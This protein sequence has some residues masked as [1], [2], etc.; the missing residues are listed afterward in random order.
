MSPGRAPRNNFAP[1]PL[2][3]RDRCRNRVIAVTA[4]VAVWSLLWGSFTW[5]NL[6]SGLAVATVVLTVFPLPP[7]TFAGRVHPLGVLRFA[8]R[9][10]LDL[11][12]S[13]VQVAALAFRIGHIPR[14]AVIAVPLAVPSDLNLTLTA[15]A[16]CLVPGSIVI[17]VDRVTGTLYVHVLGVRTRAEAERFRRSVWRLEARIITAIGSAAERHL[18]AASDLTGPQSSTDRKGP[19]A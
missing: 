6:I 4:L 3:R 9:F 11:V 14:S 5:A 7:V 13:S 18:I 2:T 16:L 8:L 1:A 17:D 12:V 10:L 19:R 15:E